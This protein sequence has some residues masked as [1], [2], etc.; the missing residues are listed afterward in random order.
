MSALLLGYVATDDDVTLMF[1]GHPPRTVL[2]DHQNYEALMD[3][4]SDKDHELAFELSD[5]TAA[6]ANAVSD[7]DGQVVVDSGEVLF[8][9]KAMH[10]EFID[11]LLA[12]Y[13]AG[14]TVQPVLNM[15]T[16]LQQNPSMSAR[17]EFPLWLEASKLPICEDGRFLAYKVVRSDYYD[18]HSGTYLNVPGAVISEERGQ[19]DD[20]RR[21]ACSKG[22]HFAALEYI[23]KM[24]GNSGDKVMLVRGDPAD[25]VAIPYDYKNQ[26]GRICKYE[27]IEEIGTLGSDLNLLPSVGV[28]EFSD[29]EEGLTA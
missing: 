1:S 21:V 10:G 8:N 17:E 5:L 4:L 23:T 13:N 14:H 15:L 28:M 16:R 19:V 26:K 2:V 3:A 29:Y 22:L 6:I 9:G 27:V 24:F 12:Q 7:L 18:K 20:N 25:V 11:R